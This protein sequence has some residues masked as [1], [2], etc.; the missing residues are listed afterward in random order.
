[1]YCGLTD[2]FKLKV[3]FT[4]IYAVLLH[5]P[6]YKFYELTYSILTHAC[7]LEVVRLPSPACVCAETAIYEL[8]IKHMTLPFAPATSTSY[9][10]G[11]T[12]LSA[13]VFPVL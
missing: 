3:F 1:M 11:I 8:S 10:T 12:L 4:F 9:N 5:L 2:Y 6:N 13:Y 7:E